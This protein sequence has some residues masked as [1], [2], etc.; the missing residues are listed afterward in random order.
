[1]IDVK[2][3]ILKSCDLLAVGRAQNVFRFFFKGQPAFEYGPILL[4]ACHVMLLLSFSLR[5]G[6]NGEVFPRD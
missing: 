5:E 4:S 1:M 2:Y 3:L 6:I